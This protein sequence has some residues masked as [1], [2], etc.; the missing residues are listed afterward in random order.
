MYPRCTTPKTLTKAEQRQLLR[1]AS[2]PSCPSPSPLPSSATAC[3][4]GR[5][6]P[7]LP[8]PGEH[9]APDNAGPTDV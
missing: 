9:H 5:P 2:L 3:C 6:L 7:P 1:G 8:L 4:S